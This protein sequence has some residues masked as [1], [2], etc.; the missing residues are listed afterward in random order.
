[1]GLLRYPNSE[2]NFQVATAGTYTYFTARKEGAGIDE[3]RTR[4]L[5]QKQRNDLRITGGAPIV[6]EDERSAK[7]PEAYKGLGYLAQWK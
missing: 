7:L 4:F 5:T 2:T 6:H 3:A 1:M